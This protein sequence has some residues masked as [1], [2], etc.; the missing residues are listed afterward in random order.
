MRK[1]DDLKSNSDDRPSRRSISEERKK[2]EDSG[3]ESDQMEKQNDST[4]DE[5]IL[6][7]G[8]SV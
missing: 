6:A 1:A 5:S 3:T 8:I 2:D 7:Q 4:L